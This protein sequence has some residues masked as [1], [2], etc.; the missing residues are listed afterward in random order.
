MAN[1][2]KPRVL[3]GPLTPREHRVLHL[4]SEGKTHEEIARSEG[5]A[6]RQYV[7]KVMSDA[8]ARLGACTGTQA[9]GRWKAAMTARDLAAKVLQARFPMPV[10]PTEAHVNHVLDELAKELRAMANRV[11][12]E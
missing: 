7:S 5:F 3:E 12:G 8:A 9:V 4:V 11:L 2:F 6:H 1:H 10:N